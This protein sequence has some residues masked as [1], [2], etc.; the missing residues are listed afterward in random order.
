MVI[1]NDLLTF[2][3]KC[4]QSDPDK[5]GVLLTIKHG[6]TGI[7]NKYVKF[8]SEHP[9]PLT[10]GKTAA[11]TTV[12]SWIKR[13]KDK[14]EE[15]TVSRATGNASGRGAPTGSVPEVDKAWFELMEVRI[16]YLKEKPATDR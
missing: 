15:E 10:H 13:G 8:L 16:E 11:P 7:A 5:W 9:N 12:S 1:N 3:A 4:I 14:A 6:K 2:I